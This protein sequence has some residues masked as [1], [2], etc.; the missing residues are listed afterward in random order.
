MKQAPKGAFFTA[1]LRRSVEILE[2]LD[3]PLGSAGRSGGLRR[4]FGFRARHQAHEEYG[5]AFRD[6]LDVAGAH[7]L[8]LRKPPLDLARQQR[9]TGMRS[10]RTV[11]ADDNFILDIAH[12]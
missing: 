9:V 2:Y 1:T 8:V 11:A 5:S 12:V 4:G 3:H 10:C 6:D 7:I